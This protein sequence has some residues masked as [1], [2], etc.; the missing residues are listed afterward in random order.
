MLSTLAPGQSE[1]PGHPHFDGGVAR[2]RDGNSALFATSRFLLEEER[3]E[4]LVLEP[5]S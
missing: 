2:W 3:L 1:H 5:G 4:R